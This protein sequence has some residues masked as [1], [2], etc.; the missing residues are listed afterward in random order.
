MATL[1]EIMVAHINFAVGNYVRS[2]PDFSVGDSIV[3]KGSLKSLNGLSGTI[4]AAYEVVAPS[5]DVEY[6]YSAT[7]ENGAMLDRVRA[8]SLELARPVETP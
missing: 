6:R 7:L 5:L 4:T 1:A 3:Y 2:Y 8:K